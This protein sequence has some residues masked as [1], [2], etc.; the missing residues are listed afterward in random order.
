MIKNL[1]MT[2]THAWDLSSP[3]S[4]I[5]HSATEDDESSLS[6]PGSPSSFD[7]SSERPSWEEI[8]NQ[9]EIVSSLNNLGDLDRAGV[10]HLEAEAQLADQR[11]RQQIIVLNSVDLRRVRAEEKLLTASMKLQS[12]MKIVREDGSANLYN[13]RCKAHMPQP[14]ASVAAASG[15]LIIPSPYPLIYIIHRFVV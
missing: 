15:R 8:F 5:S 12:I 4:P 2:D 9:Y 10:A 6:T 7:Q 11:Y 1:K 3:P 13:A 14:T